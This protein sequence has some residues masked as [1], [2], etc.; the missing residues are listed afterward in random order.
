[1]LTAEIFAET[2]K[3]EKNQR[4][5]QQIDRNINTAETYAQRQANGKNTHAIHEQNKQTYEH[6]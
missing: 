6:N 2:N 1:M 4:N 5:L 3:W